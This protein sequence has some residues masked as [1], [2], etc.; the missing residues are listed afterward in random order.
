MYRWVREYPARG[1]ASK[2]QKAALLDY[3]CGKTK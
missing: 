3:L 1:Y 2:Q